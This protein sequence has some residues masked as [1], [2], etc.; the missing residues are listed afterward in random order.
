M[1]ILKSPFFFFNKI[2]YIKSS[3]YNKVTHISIIVII[4][5]KKKKI[6]TLEIKTYQYK[7]FK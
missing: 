4:E 1:H 6:L 7:L 2:S 3:A 5:F